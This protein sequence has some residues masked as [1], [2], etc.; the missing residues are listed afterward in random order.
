MPTNISFGVARSKYCIR[1]K[2]R[3][4]SMCSRLKSWNIKIRMVTKGKQQQQRDMGEKR[5]PRNGLIKMPWSAPLYC[6]MLCCHHVPY[7]CWSEMTLSKWWQLASRSPIWPMSVSCTTIVEAYTRTH[8]SH[9]FI[10]SLYL[11]VLVI[12]HCHRRSI[13][14]GGC[15]QTIVSIGASTNCGRHVVSS[16]SE[17]EFASSYSAQCQLFIIS[18]LS[19]RGEI[20][21]KHCQTDIG[22]QRSNGR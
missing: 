14:F 4:E 3:V 12:S 16:V 10:H 15:V 22:W 13:Q 2:V 21:D 6:V 20:Q 1:C 17:R 5:Q 7:T 18:M 8:S 9:S 19:R 11:R